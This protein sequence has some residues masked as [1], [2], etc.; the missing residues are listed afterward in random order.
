MHHKSSFKW[1][2]RQ[3]NSKS[4]SKRA[5]KLLQPNQSN[6]RID[7]SNINSK[8]G[9]LP[10]RAPQGSK[11]GKDNNYIETMKHTEQLFADFKNVSFACSIFTWQ[12]WFSTFAEMIS[13]DDFNVLNSTRKRKEIINISLGCIWREVR[14]FHN[15]PIWTHDS[16]KRSTKPTKGMSINLPE[17]WA[18]N[19]RREWNIHGKIQ[20][21]SSLPTKSIQNNQSQF[22]VLQVHLKKFIKQPALK[23]I[24]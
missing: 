19:K 2:T 8:T 16:A 24:W 12:M 18:T 5:G 23:I 9:Y 6:H 1:K 14:D 3:G 15:V 11:L 13:P 10:I 20:I 17:C 22:L 4:S 7:I 21:S